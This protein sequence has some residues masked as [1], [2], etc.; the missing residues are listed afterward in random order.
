MAVLHFISLLLFA[1]C[2]VTVAY[3]F[4]F[5]IA[6]HFYKRKTF[7]NNDKF[8]KIAVLIPSYKEDAVI[9]NSA[10]QALLQN[11]PSHFYDVYVIA[12][13]LQEYTINDLKKRPIQLLELSF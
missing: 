5:S 2:F 11:Y 8:K 1:L 3:T 7:S 12:Y 4:F 9:V 6:G 13:S 10:V